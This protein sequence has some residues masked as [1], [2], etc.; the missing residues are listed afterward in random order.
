[1]SLMMPP[2]LG[3]TD[4]QRQLLRFTTLSSVIKGLAT[5]VIVLLATIQ[6]LSIFH[7]PVAPLLAS[8]G[9]LGFGVTLAAQN[10]VKD[11]INGTLILVEDQYAIGDTIKVAGETGIVET[12]NL[13]NTQLRNTNGTLITIPHSKVSVIQNMSKD[14]VQ[15]A[16]MIE[17]DNEQNLSAAVQMMQQVAMELAHTPTWQDQ[18]LEPTD[19]V[20]VDSSSPPT[21]KL[22][23]TLKTKPGHQRDLQQAF[24]ERLTQTLEEQQIPFQLLPGAEG[25]NP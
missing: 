22:C 8:A 9:I 4:P 19:T 10:L 14:W 23:L 11:V 1:M 15:I 12:M 3:L 2:T 24:N 20:R 25:H 5:F 21:L 17:L 13:R 16:G 7:I 6:V 18:M